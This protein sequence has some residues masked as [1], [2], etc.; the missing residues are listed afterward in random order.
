[1]GA[2]SGVQH[3]GGVDPLPLLGQR[4]AVEVAGGHG[5]LHADDAAVGSDVVAGGDLAAGGNFGRGR[6]ARCLAQCVDGTADPA[7]G[8]EVVLG[9]VERLAV[10]LRVAGA[11]RFEVVHLLHGRRVAGGVAHLGLHLRDRVAGTAAGV[12]VVAGQVRLAAEHGLVLA[13]QLR[14]V[15]ALARGGRG[16]AV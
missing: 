16:E 1:R 8:V 11:Q 14:Q 7:A 3:A 4:H 10:I 15:G 5:P 2:H 9:Q 13:R 6:T 12:E